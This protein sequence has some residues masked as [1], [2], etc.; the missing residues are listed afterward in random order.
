VSGDYGIRP[1]VTLLADVSYN[2][3]DLEARDD[4]VIEQD[5]TIGGVLSIRLDY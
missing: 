2:T 3:E 1:G 5:N 4:D